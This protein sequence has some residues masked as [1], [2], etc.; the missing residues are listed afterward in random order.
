MGEVADRG[1]EHQ[2]REKK[3]L[4]PE[5]R[6]FPQEERRKETARRQSG[7]KPAEEVRGQADELVREREGVNLEPAAAPEMEEGQPGLRRS[8]LV[9]CTAC[10][11]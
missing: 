2:E 7:Q 4:S 10:A 3:R 8:P 1:G 6:S 11:C 5:S 9:S